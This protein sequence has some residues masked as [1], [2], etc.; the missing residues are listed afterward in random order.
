MV[1][2]M[3]CPVCGNFFGSIGE[4]QEHLNAIHFKKDMSLRQ[5]D[6]ENSKQ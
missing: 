3:R 1:E 4:Y 5:M 2:T 6:K